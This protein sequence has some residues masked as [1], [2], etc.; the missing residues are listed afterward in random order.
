MMR[1]P[2]AEMARGAQP[3]SA[4][5]TATCGQGC[6]PAMAGSAASAVI[7]NT[8]AAATCPTGVIPE[9]AGPPRALVSRMTSLR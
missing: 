5:L 2:L 7:T 4:L 1:A 9:L 6:I 3:R 8:A